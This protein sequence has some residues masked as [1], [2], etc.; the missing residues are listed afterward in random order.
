[1]GAEHASRRNFLTGLARDMG[2]CAASA[3]E[4]FEEAAGLAEFFSSPQ[5]SYG[6]TLHYPR[7]LFEEDA[8]RLGID[9]DELGT[10]E[11]VRRIVE[12]QRRRESGGEA[13]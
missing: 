10:E 6:V 1:M 13:S 2:R 11:A 8:K 3:K 5:S 9:M 4:C 7:E 12:D